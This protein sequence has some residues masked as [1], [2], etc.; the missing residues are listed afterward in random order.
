[1]RITPTH[2]E[3]GDA[4]ETLCGD[5]LPPVK[6]RSDVLAIAA[7]QDFTDPAGFQAFTWQNDLAQLPF[8]W[9]PS[10]DTG[11]T[12]SGTVEILAVEIGGDVGTRLTTE[13]EWNIVG[14]VAVGYPAPAAVTNDDAA[15]AAPTD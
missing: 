8:T 2:D 9:A 15:D 10:G 11:P 7:V 3:D 4:T 6:Q 5:V 1:V 12:Y 13:A 14:P